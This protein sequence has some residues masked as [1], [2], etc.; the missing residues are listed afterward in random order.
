M[1]GAEL[2]YGHRQ[3][4]S[5]GWSTDNFKIQFSFKYNFSHNWGGN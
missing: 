3:N 5:D 4:F 2:Q 1:Y